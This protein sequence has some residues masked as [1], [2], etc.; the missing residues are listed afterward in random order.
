MSWVDSH[1]HLDHASFAHDLTDV[2]R[3]AMDEGISQFV[4]PGT[5]FQQWE[6]QEALEQKYPNI[7][8]AFGIHPWFCDLHAEEHLEQLDDLLDDAV[9]VGECG[10]DLMPN[11]PDIS[12]Q[13]YW[14]EAQ[15]ALASKHDLPAIVHSVKAHHLVLDSL[16]KMKSRRGVI[17]G[18]AGNVQ[19]AQSFID[20]GYF[21]G[22]GTRL[23]K[24][25]S[26]KAVDLLTQLPLRHMLLETD[27]PDGMGKDARNEPKE[28][29][30][31]ANIVAKLRHKT[32]KEV[33]DIC[34]Q[35]AKE[36]FN[37]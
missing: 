3:S 23:I 21:I 35:N 17:H 32:P 33:L 2:M 34:S 16:K 25:Y 18:F 27:A 9:A 14:F 6:N 26:D 7:S 20:S 28:L 19:Q 8:L 13:T 4:V 30:L 5:A 31:V 29:I 37:L 10:L 22:I 24:T 36:L 12:K 15:L 11:K 1:C